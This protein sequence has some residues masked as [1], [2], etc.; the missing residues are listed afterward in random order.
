[1]NNDKIAYIIQCDIIKKI[2]FFFFFFL[3]NLTMDD[4]IL[5]QLLVSY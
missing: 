1:M 4:L 2:N 5:D 3:I